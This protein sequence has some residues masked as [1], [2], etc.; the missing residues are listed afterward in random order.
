MSNLQKCEQLS[1]FPYVFLDIMTIRRHRHSDRSPVR[2]IPVAMNQKQMIHETVFDFA[3]IKRS[4][5]RDSEHFFPS[6][7]CNEDK[8]DKKRIS[9]L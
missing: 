2:F 7:K 6:P 5:E 1:G 8:I 4:A 3:E 9:H